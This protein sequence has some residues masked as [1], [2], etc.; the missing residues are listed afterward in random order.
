MTDLGATIEPKSDQL[1][2]DDLISGPRT[3]RVTDVR[4]H[5]GD[6]PISI[7]FEGDNGKPYKPCK[8]MR[9]VLVHAWG[10]DGKAYAGRLMTLFA[11]PTVT[12]G[13]ISVGGIRI[14]HL[15]DI[16]R[17]ITIPLTITKAKRAPFT[18]RKLVSRDKVQTATESQLEQALAVIEVA[19]DNAA[20]ERT[21][22]TLRE[23]RWTK[24]QGR[25]IAEAAS[26]RRAQLSE[27]PPFDEETGEVTE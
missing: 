3:I 1:N 11:D 18:V 10:R 26:L 9:R 12:F 20:L 15:S 19:P 14:S 17:D 13:G 7:H 8:S 21:L 2:T 25:K 5:S 22:G 16:D 24:E 6:Q 4:G 23:S 27:A